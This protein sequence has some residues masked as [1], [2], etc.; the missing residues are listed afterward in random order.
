MV[1]DLVIVVFE[2]ASLRDALRV[3][4]VDIGQVF[5]V[6]V[7]ALPLGGVSWSSSVSSVAASGVFAGD[8]RFFSV[9]L[10]V[11]GVIRLGLVL[12]SLISSL[13]SDDLLGLFCSSLLAAGVNLFLFGELA[14]A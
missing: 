8:K 13:I 10:L 1:L 12:F 9:I 6:G 5:L 11:F 7:I 4:G 3:L 14:T 2:M